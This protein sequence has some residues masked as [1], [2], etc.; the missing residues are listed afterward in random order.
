MY[1]SLNFFYA[2]NE[3]NQWHYRVKRRFTSLAYY[4]SAVDTRHLAAVF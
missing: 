4:T 3:L 1:M 2:E